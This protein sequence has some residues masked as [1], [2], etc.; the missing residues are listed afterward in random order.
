MPA[1]I[2]S[3]GPASPDPL[4]SAGATKNWQTQSAVRLANSRGY[5]G[6]PV[7]FQA[8]RSVVNIS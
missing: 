7:E 2:V 5:A 3:H 4:I 1:W 6:L 8:L